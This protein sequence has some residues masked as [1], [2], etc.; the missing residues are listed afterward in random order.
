MKDPSFARTVT[1]MLRHEESG[2]LGVVL[3]QP[4]NK[5]VSEVWELIEAPP[6]DCHDDVFNGGPVPGPMIALHDSESHSEQE[7]LPGLHMAMQRDAIDSLV[8]SEDSVYRLYSGHAGWGGGQLEEE[9]QASGWLKT[10]AS[11]NEVFSD[12]E[13]LWQRTISKIGISIAAPNIDPSQV[14]SDPGLN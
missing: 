7:V 11:I 8:R 12:H 13:T 6:V 2:A 9:L 14:P 5:T 3:T 4:G 1:L 10:P